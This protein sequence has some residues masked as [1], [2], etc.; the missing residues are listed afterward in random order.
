MA[1]KKERLKPI[2]LHPHEP[3]DVIRAFLKVDPVKVKEEEKERK[4][5]AKVGKT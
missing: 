4:R 3:E 1:K 5:E 2:S